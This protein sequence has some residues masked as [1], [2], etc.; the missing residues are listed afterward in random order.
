[1]FIKPVRT[2][3]LS[4]Q[5][6]EHDNKKENKKDRKKITLFIDNVVEITRLKYLTYFWKLISNDFKRM[7]F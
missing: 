6:S 3:E 1:M 2:P 7:L 4:F 5:L